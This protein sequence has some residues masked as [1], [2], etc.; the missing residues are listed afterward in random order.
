MPIDNKSEGN[1]VTDEMWNELVNAI[2]GLTPDSDGIAWIESSTTWVVP[3]EVTTE[4]RLRITIVGGGGSAGSYTAGEDTI[5]TRGGNASFG[6]AVKKGFSGGQNVPITIGAGG[7][8]GNGGN[9][10]F[11]S[12]QLVSAGGTVG[13]ASNSPPPADSTL[14]GTALRRAGPRFIPYGQGG[15]R[16][17]NLNSD[18]GGPGLVVVEW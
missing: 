16:E 9:T 7:S 18:N 14:T 12:G 3:A 8:S 17:Y 4:T 5:T 15:R 10:D 2:N 11:N 13:P 6:Y 1:P